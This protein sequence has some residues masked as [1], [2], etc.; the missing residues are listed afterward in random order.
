M[1]LMFLYAVFLLFDDS[2]P[3]PRILHEK[4]PFVVTEAFKFGLE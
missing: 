2:P 4:N 1:S 3:P